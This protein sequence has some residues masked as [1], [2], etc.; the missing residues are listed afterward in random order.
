MKLTKEELIDIIK[1]EMANEGI[2]DFLKKGKEEP[3][4]RNPKAAAAE[5]APAE[6]V[7]EGE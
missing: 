1:E 2:M 4:P 7:A 3:T 6:V 5:A